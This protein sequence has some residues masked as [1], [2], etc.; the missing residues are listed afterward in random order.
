[1][2]VR[3][4]AWL[5]ALAVMA[6]ACTT[7]VQKTS[8]SASPGTT[9]RR[10]PAAGRQAREHAEALRDVAIHPFRLPPNLYPITLAGDDRGAGVWILAEG[11][12]SDPSASIFH[13]TTRSH[14]MTRYRLSLPYRQY[15]VGDEY[16]VTTDR[17]GDLW[18]GLNQTIIEV[19]PAPGRV[20]YFNLPLHVVRNSKGHIIH[21][22]A[23]IDA[24]TRSP[25]GKVYVAISNAAYLFVLDPATGT[26]ARLHYPSGTVEAGAGTP[27]SLAFSPQGDLYALGCNRNVPPGCREYFLELHGGTWTVPRN[28]DEVNAAGVV[29]TPR[30][31]A[32]AGFGPQF[33][34]LDRAGKATLVTAPNAAEQSPALL[35]DGSLAVAHLGIDVV[36]RSGKLQQLSIGTTKAGPPICPPIP[37]P[38]PSTGSSMPS[39]GTVKSGPVPITP[40]TLVAD[41]ARDL[42]FIPGTSQNAIGEVP[43]AAL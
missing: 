25:D 24:V 18:L 39:C 7:T 3:S 12:G 6:A 37:V 31:I 20:R 11:P 10:P 15:A 28:P 33:L 30:Y 17:R 23:S 14:L 26:L 16:G 2:R 21:V 36:S 27:D 22:P 4:L 1:M 8:P 43:A 34:E 32:F 19:S 9:E 13:W 38:S 42:W 29:S 41:A 35:G 5:A 40:S